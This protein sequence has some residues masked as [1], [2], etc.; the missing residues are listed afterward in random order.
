MRRV[1]ENEWQIREQEEVREKGEK[2][3]LRHREGG[4]M[5]TRKRKIEREIC[6][7]DR[8]KVHNPEEEKSERDRSETD[9]LSAIDSEQGRATATSNT[10]R[11]KRAIRGQTAR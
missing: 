6:R 4:Q 1:R 10:P 3:G 5:C 7:A 9:R 8:R 11:S 2:D